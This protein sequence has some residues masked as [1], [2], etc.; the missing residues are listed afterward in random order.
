[1]TEQV[2]TCGSRPCNK[3]TTLEDVAQTLKVLV[4][5]V[6]YYYYYDTVGHPYSQAVSRLRDLTSYFQPIERDDYTTKTS[7]EDFN[8][9]TWKS[10]LKYNLWDAFVSYNSDSEFPLTNLDPNF[11]RGRIVFSLVDIRM[12]LDRRLSEEQGRRY[13]MQRIEMGYGLSWSEL[14]NAIKAKV[15]HQFW[16]G[17]TFTVVPWF[18]QLARKG[19]LQ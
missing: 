6:G 4:K 11:S 18:K 12:E 2:Y 1:M 9:S 10:I 15:K 13:L 19:G 7:T 14:F 3:P 8:L 16:Y 5:A 17:Y